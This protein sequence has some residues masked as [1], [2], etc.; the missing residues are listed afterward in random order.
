MSTSIIE[1]D[2]ITSS[3]MIES[4]PASKTCYS[5]N[6]NVHSP[7]FSPCF[8]NSDSDGPCCGLDSLCL[9]NGLCFN[10]DYYGNRIQRG[11]CT[12][13]EWDKKSCVSYC[14]NGEQSFQKIL[15]TGNCECI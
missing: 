14:D 3:A 9:S 11:A 4:P 10:Q 1:E 15:P 12:D 6:E 7:E 13:R 8:P 2:Q 5:M